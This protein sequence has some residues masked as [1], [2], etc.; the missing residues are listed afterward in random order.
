MDS[1]VGKRE[2][3]AKY[4]VGIRSRNTESEYGVGI[5]SRNTESEYGVGFSGKCT[6]N[7]VN[8]NGGG[9]RSRSPGGSSSDTDR[10]LYSNSV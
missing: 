8:E 6:Q 4:G 9:N 3:G 2:C 7:F 10:L 5:R 1:G